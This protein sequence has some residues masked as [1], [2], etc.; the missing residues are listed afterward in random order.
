MDM[1][2][3]DG[4]GDYLHI[5]FPQC[6]HISNHNILYHKYIYVIICKIRKT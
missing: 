3:I 1:V 6:I 4:Y 5:L 2:V